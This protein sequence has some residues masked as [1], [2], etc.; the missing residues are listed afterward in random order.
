MYLNDEVKKDYKG[1]REALMSE[2]DRKLARK[3]QDWYKS[4]WRSKDNRG[5]FDLWAKCD[6]YWEGDVNKPQSDTDPGSNTNIA[7]S[8][9]EG[10]VDNL[11]EQEIAIEVSE[12]PGVTKGHTEKIKLMLEFV[13]EMNQLEMKL[14]RLERRRIKYG[15]C[16]LL[17]TFNPKKYKPYG[18]PD[19]KIL[20]S[21]YLFVDPNIVEFED[22][23]EAGFQIIT[24][25]KSVEWAKSEFGDIAEAIAPNYDPVESEWLFG[26][27]DGEND[28]ISQDNYMHMLVFSRAKK[29]GETKMRLVQMSA[30]GVKLWDSFEWEDENGEDYFPNDEYPIFVVPNNLR[31]GCIWA[32]GDVEL[33]IPITDLVN[34]FDDQIRIN[35]RLTG[36]VQKLVNTESGIDLNKWTNEPGLNVPFNPISNGEVFHVVQPPTMPQYIIDR[37]K[38]ALEYEAPKTTRFS[39]QQLGLRQSGVDTAT[40]ALQLQQNANNGTNRKKMLLQKTLS[41]VFQYCLQLCLHKWTSSMQFLDSNSEIIEFKP[42]DLKEVPEMI[43]T[44]DSYIKQWVETTAAKKAVNPNY[45]EPEMPKYIQAVST[46]TSKPLTKEAHYPVK[47]TV[48]AGMPSNKAFRYTVI[49]ESADTLSTKT[50]LELLKQYV[51]L[52]IDVEKELEE[53]QKER[54]PQVPPPTQDNANISPDTMGMSANNNP[55]ALGG[56]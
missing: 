22:L 9:V 27:D 55:A 29:N 13:E 30:C 39:D 44:T 14:D 50:R 6:Q 24:M 5:L 19:I 43:P 20:H 37:R 25:L 7:N 36:N 33:L 8:N 34:D 16:P 3:Y 56:M 26:E 15:S 41:D 12:T 46:K 28:D 51:G 35:A 52:P 54:A 48:G 2:E 4:A 11:I 21:A 38:Y 40:E 47:I 10:Q 23:Q 42:S 18:V 17:V 45:V 32:K 53:I 49:K 31:D 1:L